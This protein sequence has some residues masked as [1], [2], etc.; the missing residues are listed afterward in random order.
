[1]KTL[2]P[3]RK[4]LIDNSITYGIVIAA[5]IIL[6][7][8]NA[9]GHMSPSL[10]GLLVPICAYI[11][12]AISLN[13]VVGISGELSLGHAGF[14]S[15]GAFSGVV[16]S[17]SLQQAIPSGSIRLAVSMVVGALCA[18]VAGLIVGVPVLRLRG[19]YLAI[20]T[21]AFGEIIK[22]IINVLYV[23]VDQNGIHFST[24]NEMALNLEE[25]GM[26]ILKGPMGVTSN[27]KLSSFTA[28]FILVMIALVV[29]LNLINSRSG[30]AIMALRDNRI[31]A[32]SVGIG[33]TKYKLMAFVTSAVMAGAAGALYAM[34]FS[35]FAAKKFDFNTSIL[36][37]VFVVLG[38]LGNIRGSVIAAAL[39]YVLPE[40]L[41][42]F[43]DYRM[44]I[45]AVV[46]ILVMLATNNPTIKGFFARFFRKEKE[47]TAKGG[48]AQ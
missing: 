14:M 46:L 23:G 40:L 35:S 24:A 19:D 5:Y 2:S 4:R 37:L 3:G 9:G 30:R 48:A 26:A 8:M 10:Q 15:V 28:G 39:L 32:E 36:I 27:V 20:V 31:A 45:Y 1:M 17:M 7:I 43:Y 34:N 29:A 44:L 11:T 13:L 16:A 42:D 22:N 18:G 41:R 33:A 47:E 6:Q 25:G 12:M 21:L 38:G